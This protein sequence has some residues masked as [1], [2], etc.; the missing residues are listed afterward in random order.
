MATAKE[1][2]QAIERCAEDAMRD[3]SGRGAEGRAMAFGCYLAGWLGG[4]GEV[5][6]AD[7]LRKL[8][9]LPP[10]SGIHS[11]GA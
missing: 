10:A 3:R 6:V 8:L 4:L 5:V 2:R 11:D 9:D 1:M 7:T